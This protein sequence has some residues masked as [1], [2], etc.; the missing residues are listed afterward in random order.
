MTQPSHSTAWRDRKCWKNRTKPR[1]RRWA[2]AFSL[3]VLPSS[4][5][6]LPRLHCSGGNLVGLKVDYFNPPPPDGGPSWPQGF[7]DSGLTTWSAMGGRTGRPGCLHLSSLLESWMNSRGLFKLPKLISS[8]VRRGWLHCSEM[9]WRPT[10]FY[11]LCLVLQSEQLITGNHR[12]YNCSCCSSYHC[13][14]SEEP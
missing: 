7:S 6:R 10:I 13:H 1:Q 3:P 14:R 8:S 11:L 4:P 12:D 5:C 2:M 9:L